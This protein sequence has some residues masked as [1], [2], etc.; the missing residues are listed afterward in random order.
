[1]RRKKWARPELEKCPYFIDDATEF[2]NNWQSHFK[3]DLPLHLE[4]GCGK[5]DFISKMAYNNSEIN[6]IA[7][8]LSRDVLGCARRNIE[9][10]FAETG[11]E[12]DNIILVA[13]NIEKIETIIGENDIIDHIYINFCNPWP[14][15][16]HKKRRLTY[17]TQLEKYKNFL[18]LNGKISFKTDDDELFSESIEYFE[19]SGFKIIYKT[20]DLHSQNPS[21]NVLTEHEKMFT[22]QGIKT[23]FLIA[24]LIDKGDHNIE[25]TN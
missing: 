5:G 16:K 15:K 25:T 8:D 11:R 7:I 22:A 9:K 3:R 20:Y 1:M 14:K 10:E 18:K 2:K 12:V 4:L 17:P 24:E 21:D 23:K 13:Q 19:N 6:Y